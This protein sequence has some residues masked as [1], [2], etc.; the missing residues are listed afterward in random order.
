VALQPLLARHEQNNPGAHSARYIL[1]DPATGRDV[2]FSV[3][4]G[5]SSSY[6]FYWAD[7]DMSGKPFDH[8]PMSN[9][10]QALVDTWR[11]CW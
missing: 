8:Q 9:Y 3:Q 4:S 5:G 6:R 10:R 2:I 1:R 11:R 7:E